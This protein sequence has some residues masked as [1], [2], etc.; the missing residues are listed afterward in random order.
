MNTVTTTPT[1]VFLL[2]VDNTLLDNDRFAAEL[3][4]RLT[5]Q[6][7]QA[8]CDRYWSLYEQLRDTVGYADYLG[9]LQHFRREND[10]RPGLL[11]MS[12]WLLNYPF[13]NLLFPSALETIGQL[14][15]LGRTAILSDGDIVFQ[16]HKIDSA[17]LYGAVD[18]HVLIFVHKE[19][20]LDAMQARY[21]ASH[22]VM[23]DDKP[24][25]LAAM[26]RYLGERLSTVFVQQGH[27]AAQAD[28][29]AL[30][31]RPDYSIATI[32]DLPKLAAELV[33]IRAVPV[34]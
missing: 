18:G 5:Y 19:H 27:Y 21:P 15:A 3:R 24:Q 16:P 20:A 12:A 22:Y 34:A 1:T 7:G 2:D 28:L 33:R 11:A 17:G 26:K 31:P 32:G 25:L 6:F 30:Q 4:A 9:A 14:N 8:E 29:T 13:E 23:V 10:D